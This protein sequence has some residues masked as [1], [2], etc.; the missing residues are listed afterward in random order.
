LVK[1][2]YISLVNLIMDREV[3]KE[4]IQ[5]ELNLKNL[6]TEFLKIAEEGKSR[7]E[8]LT[9]YDELYDK[10]GGGGA[11]ALT[12]ELMLKSLKEG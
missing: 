2:D 12:A 9:N 3:V 5:N 1:I 8:L 10:L 7:T 11:S 4:L 6:E